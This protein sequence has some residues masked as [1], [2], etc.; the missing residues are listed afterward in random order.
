M[1]CHLGCH[2][3]FCALHSGGYEDD[4]DQGNDIWYTG[5]GGLNESGIQVPAALTTASTVATAAPAAALVAAAS[6]VAEWF[7][8][9]LTELPCVAT[10]SCLA[11]GAGV[12]PDAS[13]D[14]HHALRRGRRWNADSSHPQAGDVM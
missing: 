9:L 11:A 12:E 3:V 14:Q 2:G 4:D 1:N 7:D 13:G 8:P 5:E 6:R 10:P